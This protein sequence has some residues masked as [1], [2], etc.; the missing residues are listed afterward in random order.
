IRGAESW[1]RENGYQISIFSTNNNLDKE[2]QIL[3]NILT[4]RFDGIIVEPTKSADSNPN[5]HYY[6]NLEHLSIPY[7]M[8]NA[9]YDELEAFSSGMDYEEGGYVQTEPFINFGHQNIVG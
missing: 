7:I 9:Y 1:L 3:E 2:R 4:Q 5:I 6:L 8:I